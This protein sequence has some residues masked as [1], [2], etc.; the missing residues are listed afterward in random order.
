MS[1]IDVL[2]TIYPTL[3]QLIHWLRVSE[4]IQFK[5]STLIYK[6]FHGLAPQYTLLMTCA[7][8][9]TFQADDD[10][11]QQALSSWRYA[12]LGWLL[13][14]TE[15]SPLR[16]KAV[17]QFTRHVTKCQTLA[18]FRLSLDIDCLFVSLTWILRFSLRPR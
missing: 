8:L 17:Q 3:N 9:P 12:E 6:W 7:T 18:V 13:S 10:H 2:C 1:F 4:R 15:P 11:D 5:L 14:V 16:I